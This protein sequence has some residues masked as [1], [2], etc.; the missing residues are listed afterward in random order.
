M[1][2]VAASD[3]FCN[4]VQLAKEHCLAMA[5]NWMTHGLSKVQYQE[6]VIPSAHLWVHRVSLLSDLQD[7]GEAY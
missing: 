1:F 4:C 5:E 2:Q 7:W 3:Q 6:G